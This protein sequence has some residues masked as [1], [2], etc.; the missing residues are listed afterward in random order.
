MIRMIKVIRMIRIIRMIRRMKISWGWWSWRDHVD[1]TTR[2]Y[3]DCSG[4]CGVVV[5]A[6]L[7][8]IWNQPPP[9]SMMSHH[10]HLTPDKSTFIALYGESR[11]QKDLNMRNT[12]FMFTGGPRNEVEGQNVRTAPLHLL[13]DHLAKEALNCRLSRTPKYSFLLVHLCFKAHRPQPSCGC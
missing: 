8:L 3:D 2:F 13:S 10:D 11:L 1:G 7:L 6:N 4:S 5:R 9:S 12:V